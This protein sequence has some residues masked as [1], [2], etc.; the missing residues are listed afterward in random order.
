[1]IVIIFFL[2]VFVPWGMC[3]AGKDRIEYNKRHG[4][5]K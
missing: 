2:I 5:N 1:M 3:V 4:G